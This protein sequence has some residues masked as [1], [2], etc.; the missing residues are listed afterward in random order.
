MRKTLCKSD[1]RLDGLFFE[2]GKIYEYYEDDTYMQFGG[3]G[4]SSIF[5]KK[6]EILGY[7]SKGYAKLPIFEDYFNTSE[8]MRDLLIQEIIE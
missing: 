5:R 6:R 1:L 3:F 4:S 7:T 2:K 8:E